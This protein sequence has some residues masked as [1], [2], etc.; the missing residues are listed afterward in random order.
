MDGLGDRHHA[1]LPQPT[2]N[3]LCR[4]FAILLADLGQHRMGK[5]PVLP[6]GK[7]SPRHSCDVVLRHD[8]PQRALLAERMQFDLVHRRNDLMA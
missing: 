7:G 3:N 4:G 5:Y 6:L 2:Q 1:L 8:L